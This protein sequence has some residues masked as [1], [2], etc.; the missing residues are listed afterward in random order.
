MVVDSV[1]KASTG[2]ECGV[3]RCSD[4]HQKETR[5][6]CLHVRVWHRSWNC[7]GGGGYKCMPGYLRQVVKR[8][9]WK[10]TIDTTVYALTSFTK[11]TK[12]E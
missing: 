2:D 8:G 11:R 5:V 9:D 1:G 6:T 3:L 7:P 12:S 4:I 10:Q